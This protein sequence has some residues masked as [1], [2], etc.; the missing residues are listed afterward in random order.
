MACSSSQSQVGLLARA[1][2]RRFREETGEEQGGA[3]GAWPSCWNLWH[4]TATGEIGSRV[5]GGHKN[6]PAAPEPGQPL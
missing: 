3:G 4:A 6:R 5:S 2:L 1:Q